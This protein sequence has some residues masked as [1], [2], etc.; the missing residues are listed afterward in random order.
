VSADPPLAF[1]TDALE[2]AFGR[3]AGPTHLP[4][5]TA[6]ER[7]RFLTQD[8]TPWVEQL[9]ARFDLD[10]RV[11]PPC[12][13]RHNGMVEALSALRD[14]ERACYA[15]TAAPTAALDFFRGLR[16]IEA[17]LIDQGAATRCSMSE[18]RQ[19]PAAHWTRRP[20]TKDT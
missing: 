12:W 2:Q 18:H 20:P 8:L 17:R 3:L 11:V 4:S 7:Q 14:H 10:T 1:D 5:L 13:A 15:E 19:S 6:R 16:E 9:V